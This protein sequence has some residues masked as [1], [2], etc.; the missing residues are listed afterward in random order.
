M[1]RAATVLKTLNS[2][3]CAVRRRQVCKAGLSRMRKIWLTRHGQSMSNTMQLL[4]GDS[5]LSPRGA[6]YARKLPD[7][8]IDRVPLVRHLYVSVP[9]FL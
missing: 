6:V 5:H 7:V 4:G 8:L 2:T 1:L 3:Y 9:S